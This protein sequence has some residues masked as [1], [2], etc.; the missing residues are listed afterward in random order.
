MSV[1]SNRAFRQKS[2]VSNN[3]S[4]SSRTGHA[5]SGLVSRG[6]AEVHDL[7]TSSADQ[8]A[9]FA[10]LQQRYLKLCADAS[11]IDTLR[12]T[13]TAGDGELA[14]IIMGL[15]RLREILVATSSFDHFAQTVYLFSVRVGVVSAHYETYLPACKRLLDHHFLLT[16]A[17]RSEIGSIYVL[18]LVHKTGHH[19]N[20]TTSALTAAYDAMAKYDL[21]DDLRLRQVL[22]AWIDKDYVLWRRNLDNEPDPGRRRIM[23]MAERTMVIETL[24]RIGASYLSIEKSELEKLTGWSWNRCV[25][26]LSCGWRLEGSKIII[27]E[28]KKKA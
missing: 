10:A 13:L 2:T 19:H 18:H 5:F 4:S 21:F 6:S 8:H 26:D 16:P 7:M 11:D 12:T 27:R 14:S 3:S 24:K 28:R 22:R 20:H 1:S 17:E 15:R 25:T 9:Y 23:T